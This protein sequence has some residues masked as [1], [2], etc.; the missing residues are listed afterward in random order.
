MNHDQVLA[1]IRAMT[2]KYDARNPASIGRRSQYK[3]GW[4]DASAGETTYTESTLDRLTWRN[5]GYRLGRQ[6]GPRDDD[7]IGETFDSLVEE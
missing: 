5:L 7:E 1:A 3:V 4:A 2:Y 6:L